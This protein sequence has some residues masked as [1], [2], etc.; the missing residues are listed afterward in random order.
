MEVE[1]EELEDVSTPVV[2][3]LLKPRLN[4]N[5]NLNPSKE[6]VVDAKELDVTT[7]V[8][9]GGGFILDRIRMVFK[10]LCDNLIF[11]I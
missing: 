9:T 6:G 2:D 8:L 1:E 7:D 11:I 4:L 10:N 3:A 5:L